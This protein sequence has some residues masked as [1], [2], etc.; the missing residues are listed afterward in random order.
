LSKVQVARLLHISTAVID[1][2]VARGVFPPPGPNGKYHLDH[3]VDVES[4]E[5]GTMTA[6][7][8]LPLV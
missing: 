1:R 4:L 8:F 5:P 2:L 6:V 3:V 7:G